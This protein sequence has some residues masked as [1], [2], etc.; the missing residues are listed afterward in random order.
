MARGRCRH[1]SCSRLIWVREGKSWVIVMQ[2]FR[3]WQAPS[4]Y[5]LHPME[6][7]LSLLNFLNKWKK[8]STEDHQ[9]MQELVLGVS[10]TEENLRELELL[11]K[12]WV[13][14]WGAQ[15]VLLSKA[16]GGDSAK[17]EV[18]RGKVSIFGAYLVLLFRIYAVCFLL[19][20]FYPSKYIFK[21]WVSLQRT[22]SP[23]IW[24][25]ILACS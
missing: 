10:R 20:S 23:S 5:L 24:I 2:S 25:Y 9:D 15:S 21:S 17:R 7:K 18:L 4:W 8:Q 3:D 11:R 19:C 6:W 1:S 16:E 13:M 14:C 22:H 12:N